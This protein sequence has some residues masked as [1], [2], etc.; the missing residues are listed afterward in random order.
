MQH[1]ASVC[2]GPSLSKDPNSAVEF[3]E[4]LYKFTELSHLH[5]PLYIFHLPRYVFSYKHQHT[6]TNKRHLLCAYP[7]LHLYYVLPGNQWYVDTMV[8]V[9][10]LAGDFVAEPVWH[11]VVMIVTNNLGEEEYSIFRY[12]GFISISI[13]LLFSL[14]S[15][16][17]L[18]FVSLP[19]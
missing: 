10:L 4:L 8:S 6:P 7:Y 5:Q 1:S 17:F 14:T 16:S 18:T 2:C 12:F 15:F 13:T 11:R 3:Q 9:I 19:T